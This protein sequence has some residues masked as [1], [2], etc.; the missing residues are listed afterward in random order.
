MSVR[1]GDPIRVG[2][3]V[4]A[5][6]SHPSRPRANGGR[7]TQSGSTPARV[8]GITGCSAA[9]QWPG[10]PIGPAAAAFHARSAT[11]TCAPEFHARW[12]PVQ[13]SDRGQA[14]TDPRAAAA[15]HASCSRTPRPWKTADSAAPTKTSGSRLTVGVARHKI[16]PTA[17]WSGTRGYRRRSARQRRRLHTC[18]AQLGAA[19]PP[20]V[21]FKWYFQ[22]ERRCSEIRAAHLSSAARRCGATARDITGCL[23][24]G[25]WTMLGPGIGG[26]ITTAAECTPRR[27]RL[28]ADVPHAVLVSWPEHNQAAPRRSAR[29][30]MAVND[31][32]PRMP[33]SAVSQPH[34]FW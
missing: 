13:A 25:E 1:V 24:C 18:Q 10:A 7:E 26:Q 21:A 20:H 32:Q 29:T 31:L 19:V 15:A 4:Q 23:F 27:W 34:A 6:K 28:R 30:G 33:C 3:P 11:P 16:T 8:W 9:R 5:G 12:T 14:A 22:P 17:R 2:S